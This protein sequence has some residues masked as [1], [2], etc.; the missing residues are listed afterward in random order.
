M[1]SKQKYITLVAILIL[2]TFVISA[3]SPSRDNGFSIRTND[4]KLE[5]AGSGFILDTN[6]NRVITGLPRTL[7]LEEDSVINLMALDHE[8]DF[9][10]WVGDHSGLESEREQSI[11]MNKDKELIAVF[12]DPG[13]LYMAGNINHAWGH[14]D[15]IGY[16][17]AIIGHDELEGDAFEDG[18]LDLYVRETVGRQRN[19]IR[20]FDEDDELYGD[21]GRIAYEGPQTANVDPAEFEYIAAILRVEESINNEVFLFVYAEYEEQ[22]QIEIVILPDTYIEVYNETLDV[23]DENLN[24]EDYTKFR[25]KVRLEIENHKNNDDVNYLLGDTIETS[26][27][28]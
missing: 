20:V 12:E 27:P 24:D 1:K 26:N 19:Y 23:Y 28:F 4:L 9:L 7:E 13:I 5:I 21:F 16:W 3:C 15:V 2:F 14:N 6:E 11:L 25:E 17:K 18:T 22:Q 10:F 8:E